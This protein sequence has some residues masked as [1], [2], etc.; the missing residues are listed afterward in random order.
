LDNLLY[1]PPRKIVSDIRLYDLTRSYDSL[2]VERQMISTMKTNK[3]EIRRQAEEFK[4]NMTGQMKEP[5][6]HLKARNVLISQM[7]DFN[8]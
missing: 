8:K 5:Y 1:E 6:A 3:D 2:E 7:K 4:G